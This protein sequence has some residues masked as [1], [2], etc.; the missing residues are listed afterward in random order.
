MKKEEKRDRTWTLEFQ[1]ILFS[2]L[3]IIE[4]CRICYFPLVHMLPSDSWIPEHIS[5]KMTYIQSAAQSGLKE[6]QDEYLE[7]DSRTAVSA[8]FSDTPRCLTDVSSFRV[9]LYWATV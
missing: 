8:S 4:K 9:K 6:P 2:F 3:V 1:S 7:A 5:L